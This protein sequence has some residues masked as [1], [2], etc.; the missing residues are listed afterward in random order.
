VTSHLGQFGLQPER[1]PL[2]DNPEQISH[3]GRIG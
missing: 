3:A 1:D 2:F